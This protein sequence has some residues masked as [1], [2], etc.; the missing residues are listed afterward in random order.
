[1]KHAPRA[2]VAPSPTQER[3]HQRHL[4][5]TPCA[6]RSLSN[7]RDQLQRPPSTTAP[8][9]GRRRGH[10]SRP[11]SVASRCSTAACFVRLS[12]PADDTPWRP[13]IRIECPQPWPAVGA[14]TCRPTTRLGPIADNL[15]LLTKPYVRCQVSCARRLRRLNRLAW[16]GL[17]TAPPQPRDEP[18]AQGDG[19]ANSRPGTP[20]PAPFGL[21]LSVPSEA[22]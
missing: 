19:L 15:S 6:L 7:T 8:M 21:R 20:P 18:R 11:L 16:P 10:T 17:M 2:F 4:P 5:K 13:M 12:P 22:R 14:T 1:M 9:S 3:R